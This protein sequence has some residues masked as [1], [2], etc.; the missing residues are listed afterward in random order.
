MHGQPHIRF[1]YEYWSEHPVIQTVGIHDTCH[2]VFSHHHKFIV[3]HSPYHSILYIVNYW[4]ISHTNKQRF[5]VL[6]V[7][8][9]QTHGC[10]HIGL[11]VRTIFESL[12]PKNFPRV[13]QRTANSVRHPPTYTFTSEFR[14]SCV[15]GINNRKLKVCRKKTA[16]DVTSFIPSLLRIGKSVCQEFTTCMEIQTAR[17]RVQGHWRKEMAGW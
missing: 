15:V 12:A 17:E 9:V 13:S 2:P 10:W 7:S 14:T 4:Q 8:T 1:P 16:S 6:P 11:P 3:H 5:S